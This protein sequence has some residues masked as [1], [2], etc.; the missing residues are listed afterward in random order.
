MRNLKAAWPVFE[1]TRIASAWAGTI[2]V[3]HDSDTVISNVA[4]LSGLTFATGLSGHGFGNSP[5]AE[6]LAGD[7]M[8]R[9]EPLID[10][11]PYSSDRFL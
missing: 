10:L 1:Q 6:Q 7:L 2:D 5:A 8:S 4:T 9:E 11:S 3:T